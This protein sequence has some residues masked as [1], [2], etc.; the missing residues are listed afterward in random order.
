MTTGARTTRLAMPTDRTIGVERTFDAPPDLVW[1]AFT[2]P[3][4]VSRWWGRGNPLD[5]QRDEVQRGGHWR[6]VEHAPEGDEGFEGR[7]REV[8]RPKRISRTF[9]WDGLPGYVSVETIELVD[10]GDGTTRMLAASHFM[11]PEERDGMLDEGMQEGMEQSYAALDEV[12]R[13]LR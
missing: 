3:E 9:E 7:Y 1:R 11:S 12:L 8:D 6:Y 5:I 4:L 2:E 10:N 13:T